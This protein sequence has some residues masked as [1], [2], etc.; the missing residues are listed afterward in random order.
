MGKRAKKYEPV[1]LNVR[2]LWE[3]GRGHASHL[4][5]GGS[6]DHRPKRL[7]TRGDSNRKAMRDFD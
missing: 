1:K 2:P 5:G 7:R 3:V 6:H 4:S